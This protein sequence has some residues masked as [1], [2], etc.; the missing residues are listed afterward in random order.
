[1]A[2]KPDVVVSFGFSTGVYCNSREVTSSL[3]MFRLLFSEESCEGNDVSID[4]L[5][6]LLAASIG[7]HIVHYS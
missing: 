4:R 6:I 7:R 5:L 2:E 1:M 3:L